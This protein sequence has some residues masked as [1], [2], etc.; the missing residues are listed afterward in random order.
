MTEI[1]HGESIHSTRRGAA[2]MALALV[3]GLAASALLLAGLGTT[4]A[5]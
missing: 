1:R 2:R 4:R 5:A 3:L